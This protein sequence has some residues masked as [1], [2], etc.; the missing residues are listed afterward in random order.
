MLGYFYDDD[1]FITRID[2][3]DDNT[4]G[5][6]TTDIPTGFN[7]PK[8]NGSEWVEGMSDDELNAIHS[9][10]ATQDPIVALLAELATL[11]GQVDT[12]NDTHTANNAVVLSLI[13]N[14]QA[15]I[16]ALKGG[17]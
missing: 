12:H 3:V 10:P 9:E 15:E 11:Q 7:K 1:G 2:Y 8:W 13:A 4:V 16:D 6:Y 14:M 5:N 17:A